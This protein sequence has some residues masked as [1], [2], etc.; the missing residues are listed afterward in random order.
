MESRRLTLL[1]RLAMLACLPYLA[2]K[3]LWV[4]GFDIGVV[5]PHRFSR[6]TW[7]AANVFTFL[8]DAIAAVVAHTLTRPAG[9]RTPAWLLLFPLWAASGLLIPLIAGVLGG[10][11][12]GVFTDLP[13]PMGSGNFLQPWVF[14]V[15]YGGFTVEAVTLLGAF[16]VYAH[17]RWGDLLRLPLGALPDT[18]TRAVQRIFLVP[19]GLLLA[20]LGAVCVLWGAGSDLGLDAAQVAARTV[21]SAASAWSEGLLLLAGAVGLL[22]LALPGPPSRL[23][24]RTALAA[25]WTGSATAFASGGWQWLAQAVPAGLS[26]GASTATAGLPGLVGALELFAGL[27]VLCAGAFALSELTVGMRGNVPGQMIVERSRTRTST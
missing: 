13:H 12:A 27:T 9:R 25:A 22:L 8:L 17:Q 24:V 1:G 3:L 16:A 26:S 15:V 4:L 14:V 7:V 20:A 10:S 11:L 5:D 21:V 19:A 2:L 18:G 6:T 23:R